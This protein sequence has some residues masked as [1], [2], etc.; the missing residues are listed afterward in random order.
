MLFGDNPIAT[1]TFEDGGVPYFS[2]LDLQE[3]LGWPTSAT[4][5]VDSPS[6]P[7]HCKRTAIEYGPDG[8]TD[9]VVLSPTGVLFWT[10][11]YDA[12]KGQKITAWAK[13]EARQLCP[14]A[15]PDDPAMFLQVTGHRTL[16]PPPLKYSGW[17]GEWN[18]LRYS[19]AYLRGPSVLSSMRAAQSARADAAIAKGL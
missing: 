14:N 12:G 8:E 3:A 7:A 17:R 19:E 4:D 2:L 15:S 5:L 18:D 11:L 16:P 10:Q 13:R 9:A 1:V 6:F